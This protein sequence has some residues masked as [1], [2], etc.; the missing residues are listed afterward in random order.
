MSLS[1]QWAKREWDW[2][3]QTLR[4]IEDKLA[5]VLDENGRGF[6]TTEAKNIL[7]DLEAPW[8]KIVKEREET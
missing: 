8:S 1:I 4:S 6:S 2:D 3:D 5:D 7:I